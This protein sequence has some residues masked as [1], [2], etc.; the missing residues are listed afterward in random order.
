[1]KYKQ[2]LVNSIG[3]FVVLA[4]AFF[5]SVSANAQEIAWNFKS[6]DAFSVTFDQ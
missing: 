6:G 4:I 2:G 1:M 5:S 3:V